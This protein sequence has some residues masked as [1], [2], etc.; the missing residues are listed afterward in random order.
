MIHLGSI[1]V[2]LDVVVFAVVGAWLFDRADDL[3]DRLLAQLHHLRRKGGRASGFLLS[4]RGAS[5]L[6]PRSYFVIQKTGRTS[7]LTQKEK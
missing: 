1:P 6:H 5:A 2:L 4:P 7:A 3:I